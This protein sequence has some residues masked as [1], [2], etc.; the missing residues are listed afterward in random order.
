M[1]VS[2]PMRHLICQMAPLTAA[3]DDGT[4]V[5]E[6]ALS[7]VLACRIRGLS[8]DAM[9][10]AAEKHIDKLGGATTFFPDSRDR[11]EIAAWRTK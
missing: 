6:F 2:K 9:V 4:V 7:L 11:D 5:A 3:V 10:K 8:L 1:S